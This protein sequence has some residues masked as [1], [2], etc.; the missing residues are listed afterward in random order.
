MTRRE[1]ADDIN[2]GAREFVALIENARRTKEPD[3]V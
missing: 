2:D 3:A 1:I